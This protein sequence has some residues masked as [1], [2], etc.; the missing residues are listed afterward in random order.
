MGPLVIFDTEMFLDMYVNHRIIVQVWKF[1]LKLYYWNLILLLTFSIKSTISQFNM[2]DEVKKLH[3]FVEFCP[4]C[5]WQHIIRIYVPELDSWRR[6]CRYCVFSIFILWHS[7]GIWYIC[8]ASTQIDICRNNG[9]KNAFQNY[10]ASSLVHPIIS[11]KY[12]R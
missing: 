3:R 1:W 9:T 8:S 6:M 10:I 4:F 7:I 11:R 12:R 5:C 2:T